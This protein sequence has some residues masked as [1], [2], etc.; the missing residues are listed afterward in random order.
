M[1]R[2]PR[3]VDSVILADGLMENLIADAG[4]FLQR[5]DW[6]MKRGIR[7]RRGYLH[8]GPPGTGKSS[9]V[10]AIASALQMDIAMLSLGDSTMDDNSISELFSSIP[11]NSIVLME[12]IDCAFIERKEGE[13]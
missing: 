2:Q 3:P 7:Y 4:K 10:V 13:D 1:R 9:A 5:R 6:Y 12:D 11:A 8:H